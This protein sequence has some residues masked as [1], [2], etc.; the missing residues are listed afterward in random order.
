MLLVAG[1]VN[2]ADMFSSGV[3]ASGKNFLDG[4]YSAH[5]WKILLRH[6]LIVCDKNILY[7]YPTLHE[8][9]KLACTWPLSSK[10]C[11]LIQFAKKAQH[12]FTCHSNW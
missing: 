6:S 7:L 2:S 8:M 10:V 9:L 5:N 1:E 12:I 4:R 11:A 3:E